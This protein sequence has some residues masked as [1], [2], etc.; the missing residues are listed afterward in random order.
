MG[1]HRLEQA[2]TAK[3]AAT[4]SEQSEWPALLEHNACEE[5]CSSLVQRKLGK[6]HHAREAHDAAHQVVQHGL[7]GRR[8]A[9]E[10]YAWIPGVA[11]TCQRCDAG[12]ETRAGL[13]VQSGKPPKTPRRRPTCVLPPASGTRLAFTNLTQLPAST[14]ATL[15]AMP[16]SGY[17]VCGAENGS[18]GGIASTC[19]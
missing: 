6:H 17:T 11:F 15:A 16:M 10:A 9:E 5:S 7:E 4:T 14:S 19:T 18:R 13:A 2:S 8:D 1:M 12:R 3:P